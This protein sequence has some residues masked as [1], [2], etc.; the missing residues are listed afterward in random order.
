MR[1]HTPQTEEAYRNTRYRVDHADGGFAIRVGESSDRLDSLLAAH[2]VDCWAYVTAWNPGSKK[3]SNKTNRLRNATLQGQIARIGYV[4]YPGRGEPDAG[5]WV[6]E[7]SFLI[8][9]MEAALAQQLGAQF[10]Q[11]AV[12]V[13]RVGGCAEL[14]WCNA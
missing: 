5:D 2:G 11:H 12:L 8:L 14:K 3:I 6:A 13:G 9:G 1:R 7:E 10:G 4:I